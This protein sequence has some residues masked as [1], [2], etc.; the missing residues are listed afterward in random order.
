MAKSKKIIID[1]NN[2]DIQTTFYSNNFKHN[3]NKKGRNTYTL[4]QYEKM[5]HE[6]FIKCL[7]QK[8][9][10]LKSYNDMIDYIRENNTF[11]YFLTIRGVNNRA[12]K[13]LLDRLRK[14][15]KDFEYVSLAAWSMNMDLHYHLLLKT[16]LSQDLIKKKVEE[17]D[18]KV[19]AIYNSK[20]LYKYFKKNINFDTSNVLMQF[21]NQDL[22]SKQIDILMYSKIINKSKGIKYK[23]IIIKNAT[24][25]QIEEYVKN[26]EYLET[27]TYEF[28][29]TNTH[30][31]IDKY[32]K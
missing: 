23:P 11:D 20:K 25:E 9:K 10:T 28:N 22:K 1:N 13:K 21:D 32:E 27:I 6:R 17:V 18:S 5:D 31:R 15:D 7:N 3:I 24:D 12:L 16:N 4:D 2:I 8:I 26:A 19:E 29:N 14:A 30:V